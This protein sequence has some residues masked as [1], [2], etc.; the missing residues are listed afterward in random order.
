M[1]RD[2]RSKFL[3]VSTAPVLSSIMNTSE[4]LLMVLDD[5]EYLI[6]LLTPRSPS[7]AV[8]GNI[9]SYV[10]HIDGGTT[11]KNGASDWCI[12][13][14]SSDRSNSN[15]LRWLVFHI[16]DFYQKSGYTCVDP[17][18]FRSINR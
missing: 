7:I 13:G 14:N 4:I 8:T 1:E 15:K 17:S 3:A 6:G 9:F 18:L 16:F 11:L 2:S 12:F 10:S 5:N